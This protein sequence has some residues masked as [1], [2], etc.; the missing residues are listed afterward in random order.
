MATAIMK[1][2]QVLEMDEG[3]EIIF[4]ISDDMPY[5]RR[6]KRKRTWMTVTEIDNL[7]G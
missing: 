7:P 4:N 3:A 1:Q 6:P 5:N 2:K